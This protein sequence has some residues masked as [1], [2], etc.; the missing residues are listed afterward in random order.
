MGE[1]DYWFAHGEYL[2]DPLV[3]VPLFIRIPGRSVARRSDVAGL[4]DLYPT[5]LGLAGAELNEH[6]PG[7]NLLAPD[8]PQKTSVVYLASLGGAMVARF[9]LVAR[10]HMYLI[11]V[12]DD[13]SVE[14]RLY[15]LRDPQQDLSTQEP[16]LA[17]SLRDQLSVVARAMLPTEAAREQAL[18]P[19]DREKLR[20]LGYAGDE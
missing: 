6:Y 12:L 9:G 17:R 1:D 20:A 15:R 4:I 18:S 7:R 3:R 16:D 10:E 19:A 8:A 2:T 13:Q 14:Q 11:T 5:L